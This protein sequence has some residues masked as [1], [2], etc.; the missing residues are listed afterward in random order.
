[1]FGLA[2]YSCLFS[3]LISFIIIFWLS[4]NLPQMD[5]LLSFQSL[6]SSAALIY[7]LSVHIFYMFV[8]F[9]FYYLSNYKSREPCAKKLVFSQSFVTGSMANNISHTRNNIFVVVIRMIFLSR[10]G[11]MAFDFANK[12]HVNFGVYP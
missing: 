8:V 4:N 6:F 12:W 7:I 10:L 11:R 5:L 1:M 9:S 3:G 2:D